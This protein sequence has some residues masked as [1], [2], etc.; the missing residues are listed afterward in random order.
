MSEE[1]LGVLE[2]IVRG[3]PGM[4]LMK[5][6]L[7]ARRKYFSLLRGGK[8]PELYAVPLHCEV[9]EVNVYQ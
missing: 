2:Y 4:C 9:C 1:Q 7:E 6:I 8:G 3:V 5:F